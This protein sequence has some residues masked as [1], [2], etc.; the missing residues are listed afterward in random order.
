MLRNQ[1]QQWSMVILFLVCGG[2]AIGIA[3]SLYTL[4]VQIAISRRAMRWYS[5]QP[6]ARRE[7]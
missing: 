4:V 5:S 3:L 7:E 2:F 6:L 1:L